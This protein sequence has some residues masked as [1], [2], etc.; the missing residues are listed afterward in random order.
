MG[1]HLKLELTEGEINQILF[2][3]AEKPYKEVFE[4]IYKIR[5]Q[6]NKQLNI[7]N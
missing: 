5:E 3:L 6:S 4:L 1:E 7:N 2:T